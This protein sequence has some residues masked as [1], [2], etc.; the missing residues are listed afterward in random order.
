MSLTFEQKIIK[1]LNFLE[2][3][4]ELRAD[5]YDRCFNDNKSRAYVILVPYD[6]DISSLQL[7]EKYCKSVGLKFTNEFKCDEN[8][9]T[10]Q[11]RGWQRR[12]Q[13]AIRCVAFVYHDPVLLW[14]YSFAAR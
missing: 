7:F 14:I 2:T 10:A 8:R 6:F 1:F 13:P 4:T 3:K 5:F 9:T 12:G 11:S